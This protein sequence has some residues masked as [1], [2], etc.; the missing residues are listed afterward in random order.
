MIS[1]LFI[2]FEYEVYDKLMSQLKSFNWSMDY[3][4]LT[5]L[6]KIEVIYFYSYQH[7]NS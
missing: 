5:F 2:A 6:P 7:F 4:V 3:K 1:L